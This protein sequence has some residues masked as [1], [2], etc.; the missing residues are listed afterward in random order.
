MLRLASDWSAEVE[1]CLVLLFRIQL[2]GEYANGLNGGHYSSTRVY[3]GMVWRGVLALC[4]A[5]DAILPTNKTVYVFEVIVHRERPILM[6][7]RAS[8]GTDNT[9][10]RQRRP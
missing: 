8:S 7:S 6:K 4:R 2:R 1:K 9:H 3:F 5:S 10:Q